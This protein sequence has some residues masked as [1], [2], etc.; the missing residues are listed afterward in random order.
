MAM[1]MC[2]VFG[3]ANE[4]VTIFEL[5]LLLLLLLVLLLYHNSSLACSQKGMGFTDQALLIH[6]P[7][8]NTLTIQH[9]LSITAF[10][11]TIYTAGWRLSS[12]KLS[13]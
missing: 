7:A 12:F 9:V 8:K 3:K 11:I 10:C 2:V 5:L 1:Y 13:C 4:G 6:C